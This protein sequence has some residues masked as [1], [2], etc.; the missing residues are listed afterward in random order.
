MAAP[1]ASISPA[2]PTPS[3][4]QVALRNSRFA[5]RSMSRVEC[6][7]GN[8]ESGHVRIVCWAKAKYG[9]PHKVP[10]LFFLP[11]LATC[12]PVPEESQVV[13]RGVSRKRRG[14]CALGGY[15]PFLTATQKTVMF[16]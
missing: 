14:K 2:G 11:F 1:R 9:G 8:A 5:E 16:E 12:S 10:C 7:R 15:V 3:V 4:E 6:V 13:E